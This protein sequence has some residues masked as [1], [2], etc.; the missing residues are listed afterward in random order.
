[1]TVIDQ[2]KTLALMREMLDAENRASRAYGGV[3]P[4]TENNTGGQFGYGGAAC[5]VGY[6]G[7]RDIHLRAGDTVRCMNIG[8]YYYESE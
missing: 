4:A 6:H 1:M 8:S 5:P 3:L 7:R 2:I